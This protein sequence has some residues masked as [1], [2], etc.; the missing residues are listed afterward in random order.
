LDVVSDFLEMAL[1]RTDNEDTGMK[2]II[3]TIT[4]LLVTFSLSLADDYIY[5][6]PYGGKKVGKI[7]DDGF[8]YDSPYGG[9]KIGRVN[10]GFVYDSPYGGKKVGRINEDGK[11][12]DEPYGRQAVG[13]YEDGKVYDEPYGGKAIG[14]TKNKDGSGYWLL[15]KREPENEPK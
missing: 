10:D 11:L 14:K 2:S 4:L 1:S 3:V 6:S 12:Y 13:R 9:K 5:D 7:D 15:K 8:I